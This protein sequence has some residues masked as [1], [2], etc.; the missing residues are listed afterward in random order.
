MITLD[1]V[2]KPSQTF[3]TQEA[4]YRYILDNRIRYWS[5]FENDAFLMSSDNTYIPGMDREQGEAA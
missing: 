2:G 3:A 1:P 5:L 4:A